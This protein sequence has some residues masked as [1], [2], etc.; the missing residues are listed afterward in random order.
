MTLKRTILPTAVAVAAL[1]S[2]RWRRPDAGANEG[3]DVTVGGAPC[4]LEEHHQNAVNSKDHTSR[5]SRR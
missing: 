1:A 4:I 3:A 2:P 5:W